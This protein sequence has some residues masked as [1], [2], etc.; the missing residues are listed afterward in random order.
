[1]Q[2]GQV[3]IQFVPEQIVS[4]T[5]AIT[6]EPT[7]EDIMVPSLAPFI[8]EPTPPPEPDCF[9]CDATRAWLAAGAAAILWFA[10][11]KPRRR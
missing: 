10:M 3:P 1:M 6:L 8:P 2:I 5:D 11:R 7:R 4:S 9:F